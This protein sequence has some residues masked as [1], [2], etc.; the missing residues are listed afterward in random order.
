MSSTDVVQ[1]GL[2]GHV[3][4]IRL[5]DEPNRNA[6]SNPMRTE[7]ARAFAEM[8]RDP[9]V[10]AV[11]LTATGR[12]FCAGG[13]LRMMRDESDPWSS[14]KRLRQ[15]GRWMTDLMQFP[16]PVVVGVNGAAVGG[17][18]GIALIGDVVYA[19]ESAR[20][21]SGF[22]RLG[23]LPDIATM[24]TLPRLVGMTR[25]RAFVLDGETWDAHQ[26]AQAGLITQVVTDEELDTRCLQRAQELA[27]GPV[28]AVGLI[29]WLMGRSFESSLDEMLTYENLGQTL[30][31]STEA[32]REGLYA[33][34]EGRT[35]DFVTASE[36]EP[37]QKAAR[38][39]M[40]SGGDSR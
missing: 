32:M 21:I 30:A 39:L 20:F 27:S 14:H 15:S 12:A 10:R 24:Y 38:A 26:A 2:D 4:I 5:S 36:R 22:L 17:G 33:L 34:R 40:V 31:Y 13:D 19:A 37:A 25:A 28:E 7:L 29:K 6:L 1:T 35:A 9:D 18:I 23:L 3:G 8:E 11:Y 16:K